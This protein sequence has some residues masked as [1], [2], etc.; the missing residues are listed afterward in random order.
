ML[1]KRVLTIIN[2]LMFVA[3]F[4][5]VVRAQETFPYD[6]AMTEEQAHLVWI[7]RP[8]AL[9]VVRSTAPA[10]SGRRR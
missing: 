6:P 9:T 5:V 7:E 8:P 10:C 2:V 4:S 1:N 3:V